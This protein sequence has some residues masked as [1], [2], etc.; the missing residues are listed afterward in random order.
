MRVYDI[1]GGILQLLG[2][3]GGVGPVIYILF[4]F[5][6]DAST[7][8]I[9][10]GVNNLLLAVSS[11]FCRVSRNAGRLGS[12][13]R[14]AA[15]SFH[16][17]EFRFG[18]AEAILGAFHLGFGR[19]NQLLSLHRE[20]RVSLIA[21]KK[22]VRFVDSILI[23]P[24]SVLQSF[25][26]GIDHILSGGHLLVG[27][28][29]GGFGGSG[30]LLGL[31][32]SLLALIQR[33]SRVLGLFREAVGFLGGGLGGIV[34]VGDL[35]VDALDL[36]VGLP[37]GVAGG[38]VGLFDFLVGGIHHLRDLAVYLFQVF[39]DKF[40]RLLGLFIRL[41]IGGIFRYNV[42]CFF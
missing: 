24:L 35:L 14:A 21:N 23:C 15:V 30:G 1:L 42:S 7:V 20:A 28:P 27:L 34:G 16:S 11:S 5:V 32:G 29:G 12:I 9:F 26:S 38:S 17:S 31:S 2:A 33:E 4:A 3:D 19:S 13:P 6:I 18:F 22:L 41:L 40:V 36:L 10:R 8:V 25:L 39:I 37:G